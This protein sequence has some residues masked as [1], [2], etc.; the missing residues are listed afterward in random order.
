MG[1]ASLPV[2]RLVKTP[3]YVPPRKSTVL[4]GPMARP[5]RAVDR[6]KGE[7]MLPELLGFPF[8]D[9]YHTVCLPAESRW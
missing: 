6:S 2:S 8:G 4:P 9:T 3:P 7:E 5:L 1:C